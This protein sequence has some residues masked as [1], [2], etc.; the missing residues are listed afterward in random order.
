[1]DKLKIGIPRSLFFYHD[2]NI[3]CKFFENLGF[4]AVISPK[5]NRLIFEEGMKYANDE[6]CMSL[7]VLIGH[8][9]YLTNR[10]DYVLIPRIDNYG[11]SDQTCT[12]FLAL[13]DIIKNLFDVNIISYNINLNKS[14]TLLKGLWQIGKS[15][16]M[17]TSAIV[18]AYKN[19]ID[20]NAHMKQKKINYNYS[21]LY[22]SKLKILL[23]GHSY[24]I[25]DDYIGGPIAT[26]LKKLNCEILYSDYFDAKTTNKL[27]CHFSEG[28]YWKYSKESIGS[29]KLV[30]NNI[31]G[32]IFLT[33]FPCGLD[34]LVNELVM[35]KL[36]IPNINLVID[37][38]NSL[39]GVYTRLESF[40]DILEQRKEYA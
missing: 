2:G 17:K 18:K 39:A 22:S 34:S 16:N 11:V 31:D 37:D 33:A 23:I 25:H 30:E 35:R 12:N 19:A 36:E 29:I 15:F 9:S 13:Y 24:N 1:M 38:I 6:M 21:K 27:A 26:Y 32:I 14:E 10:C 28:L 5:T 20:Y 3:L 40:V 4:E 8:V 7:K